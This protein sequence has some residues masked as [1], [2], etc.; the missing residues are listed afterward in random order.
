MKDPIVLCVYA[1][2]GGAGR[3]LITQQL[4]GAC[5]ERGAKVLL[6]DQDPQGSLS[7][8][9]FGAAAVE[10]LRP[11]ETA[12]AVYDKNYDDLASLIHQTDIENIWIVPSSDHM[13]QYDVFP[14]AEHKQQ[15]FALRRYVEST[16]DV[17]DIVLIDTP[18][19][20]SNLPAI[21]ALNA[22]RYVLTPVKPDKNSLE[23]LLDVKTRVLQVM[24]T[25]NVE[26]VDLGCFVT[27]FDSRNAIHKVAQ[28]QIRQLY[29][30][31]VFE[32]VIK[33]RVAYTEAQFQLAPIT[34][35]KPNS[36][37]SDMIRGL[38][39]EIGARITELREALAPDE[40]KAANQ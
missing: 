2:K 20:A 31:Q 34:H 30:P 11:Y 38:L 27:D 25:S 33:R 13:Q 39:K 6:I 37:E 8:N 21:A 15:S 19:N 14:L 3:T 10:R 16:S 9:F 23:A 18:P 26:L 29:G 36:E 32:T 12:S 17:F 40:K 35:V 22:S 5:A 1:R 4:A 7:K 28:Q 24:Q